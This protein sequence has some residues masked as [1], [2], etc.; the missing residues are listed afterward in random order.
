M[1]RQLTCIA[2]L[3]VMTVLTGCD[4]QATPVEPVSSKT[5]SLLMEK[6]Q[7]DEWLLIDVRSPEEF[8]EGHIPGAINMPHNQIESYVSQLDDY[9]NQRI[10][11]YC[12]SGRR[13][14]LTLETLKARS[15]TDVSHLE[16]DMMGWNAAG[17]PVDR[18]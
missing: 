8:A 14:M 7:N 5:A 16:G 11:V 6:V 2:M 17:L 9:K 10:I 18:M 12:Q 4:G 15:F 1:L 13:A 3:F